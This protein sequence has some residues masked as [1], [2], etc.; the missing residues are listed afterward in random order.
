MKIAGR[1]RSARP[2]GSQQGVLGIFASWRRQVAAIFIL[3]SSDQER[4]CRNVPRVESASDV[5]AYPMGEPEPTALKSDGQTIAPSM[6]TGGVL[7]PSGYVGIA[8]LSIVSQ[9]HAKA[10]RQKRQ[11]SSEDLLVFS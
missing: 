10:T 2:W 9:A 4:V 3:H 11:I 8:F 6:F 1:L 5:L 7:W